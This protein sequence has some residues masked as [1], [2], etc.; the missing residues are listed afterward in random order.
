MAEPVASESPV[1]AGAP[2]GK[3]L[4]VGFIKNNLRDYGMLISLVA[5]MA[6]FQVLTDGTLLRPLNLTNLVLQNSYIVIM[7]LGMLLVIVRRPHRPVGGL[8]VRLHRR[9]SPRC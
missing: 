8:G 9:A 6:L 1:V 4:H 2:T 7:A 3:R 5:I